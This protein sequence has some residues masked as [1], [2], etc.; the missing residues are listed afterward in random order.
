MQ[1]NLL[2]IWRVFNIDNYKKIFATVPKLFFLFL[3]HKSKQH[4]KHVERLLKAVYMKETQSINTSY[5]EFKKMHFYG[6]PE[7]T[8]SRF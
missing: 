2:K 4:T 3:R 1:N 8:Y 6:L 7:R 5:V